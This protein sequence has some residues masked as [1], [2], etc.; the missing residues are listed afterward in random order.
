MIANPHPHAFD[1]WPVNAELARALELVLEHAPSVF[2][3]TKGSE[4][5]LVHANTAFRRLVGAAYTGQ[6]VPITSVLKPEAITRMQSLLDRAL[7]RDEVLHDRFLGALAGGTDYW[8]C[9]IWPLCHQKLPPVG[10]TIELHRSVQQAPRQ[11]LQREVAERL[12]L[13]ALQNE[14]T[15]E[16]AE[17]ALAR[18]EFL[19][20][21]GQRLGMSLDARVTRDA[22][23]S[24]SLPIPD[25]WCIVDLVEI[26]GSISRLAMIHPNPAKQRVLAELAKQWLP[27]VGD[28]FGAAAMTLESKA[29]P[30]S[31]NVDA[32]LEAAAHSKANLRLLRELGIGSLL[33]VPMALGGRLLGAITFVTGEPARAYSSDEI[34]LAQRLAARSAEALESAHHYHEA[35]L[36]REEAELANRNR[37]RFLGNISHELRTPLNAI[38]GYVDVIAEGIHGPLTDAQQ[39]DLE[40]IRLNQEHLLNLVNEL[41]NFVTAGAPRINQLRAIPAHSAVEEAFRLIESPLAAKSLNYSCE[42]DDEDI[43]VLG[44]PERVRQILVNLLANA[45]K[46]TPPGGSI[47]TRCEAD[48]DFVSISVCDTGIGIAAGKLDAIFEPFVQV[49][50][51]HPTNGGVGLG[52]AISREL[53]RTMDGDLRVQSEFG[54]GACF[55][56]TLPRLHRP[57]SM[58][59]ASP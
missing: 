31:G 36:L 25:T 56:L 8:S 30:I 53:A 37:L 42:P 45:T 59:P 3:V 5:T 57:R 35:L 27:Q 29:L 58:P 43:V 16:R 41:L 48:E 24:I 32:A 33:T 13:A 34:E 44:D 10:L 6:E 51:A 49:D 12:L 39:S 19:S 4:H 1:A 46:F 38:V 40:R 18:S 50:P 28:P 17:S 23:A 22:V 20:E 15:A 9:T 21:A 52:L 11:A 2:A 14:E 55:T 47:S 26:D 7:T 54:V